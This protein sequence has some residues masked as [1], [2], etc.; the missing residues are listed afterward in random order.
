MLKHTGT[1]SPPGPVGLAI[2]GPLVNI[3]I[4]PAPEVVQSMRDAGIEPKSV[5]TKMMVDTG[6]ARTV[7]ED[8]VAQH[9]GLNPLRYASFVGVSQKSEKYP[10]YRVTIS[11]AMED[12]KKRRAVVAFTSDVAG[13]PSPT[14][15][16]E[17]QGLIGR[18]FLQHVRF[19]YDGPKGQFEIIDYRAQGSTPAV[20]KARRKTLKQ[21]SK[22]KAKRK[23][24][25]KSRK[26]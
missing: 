13:V 17:H 19:V 25:R 2:N 14:F 7:I 24:A 1:F 18:D 26:K 11:I 9:L 10:V 3:T 4:Q 12:E 23:T 15:S 16:A 21:K 8:K 20:S 22:A 5:N 6:A